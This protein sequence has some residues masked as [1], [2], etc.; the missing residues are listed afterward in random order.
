MDYE[1][2]YKDIGIIRYVKNSRA[3]RIIISVKPEFVRVTIPRRQ[4]LKNAQKFVEQKKDWIKK[5]SKHMNA[6]ILKSKELPK[7][8]KEE[9]REKL[10]E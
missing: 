1:I 7:I 5:H 6:L 9:S 4:T 3:K 8:E 10:R 2:E